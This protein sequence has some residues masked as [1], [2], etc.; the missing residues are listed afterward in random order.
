M[1]GAILSC[2]S[3]PMFPPVGSH[4]DGLHSSFAARIGSRTGRSDKNAHAL[5]DG[6]A[7]SARNAAP[8]WYRSCRIGRGIARG[9]E[10]R[11]GDAQ[12]SGGCDKPSAFRSDRGTIIH[13]HEPPATSSS[14]SGRRA[15]RRRCTWRCSEWRR[16]P[17]P[18]GLLGERFAAFCI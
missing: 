4:V 15:R 3:G 1:C 14:R 16:R 11:E 17:A 18:C 12:R 2:R 6:G 9:D 8:G 5:T 10:P 7:S 13:G